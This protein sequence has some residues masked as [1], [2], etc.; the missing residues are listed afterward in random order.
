MDIQLE[1]KDV[2]EVDTKL[3]PS[4]KVRGGAKLPWDRAQKDER[5]KV[6]M[7]WQVVVAEAGEY[8]KAEAMI[9]QHGHEVLEDVFAKK[10][11]GALQVRLSA[12]MLY[13]RW[14][15][16]K[17]LAPFPLEESQCYMY[18]DQ[19]RRDG[20][21]AT[22]ASSF[23]SALAFCKGTIQLGGV[24]DILQSGRISG[25]AHRSFLTKRVLRQRDALTVHQ[26]GILERLLCG[27]FTPAG[28]SVCRPLLGLHLW[29]A[30]GSGSGTAKES[31]MSQWWMV[32]ISKEGPPRA[33]RTR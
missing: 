31:S 2:A 20:A 1:E 22:R 9:Q 14:S 25:S 6:L 12:M 15:R 29:E 19:L 4:F 27:E 24:D 28:S 8:S 16:A 10:K 17:G 21:P 3:Q 5:D 32:A 23:R 7:G 26:V 11:N 13:I 33:R 30:Q 18:V